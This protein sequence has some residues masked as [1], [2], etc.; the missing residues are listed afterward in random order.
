MLLQAA[1]PAV[2]S[3]PPSPMRTME[4][5][6]ADADAADAASTSSSNSSSTAEAATTAAAAAEAVG[7]STSRGIA[8]AVR[9][10]TQWKWALYALVLAAG[11]LF[12]TQSAVG[13]SLI[14]SAAEALASIHVGPAE[15]PILDTL[16]LLVTACI[17]VPAVCKGIPG[18]WRIPR[19]VPCSCLEYCI[20]QPAC[21]RMSNL[22]SQVRCTSSGNP[23]S[24]EFPFVAWK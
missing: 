1:A 11:G 5:L 4:E 12:M 16:I 14:A 7:T 24:Q 19:R 8:G 13:Q 3:A 15:K 20:I 23:R 10:G 21:F 17:C 6:P 2:P 18:A 22:A 9:F